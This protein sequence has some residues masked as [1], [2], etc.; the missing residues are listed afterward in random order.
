MGMSRSFVWLLARLEM[1][2]WVMELRELVL[3]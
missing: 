2:L 3:H 1:V